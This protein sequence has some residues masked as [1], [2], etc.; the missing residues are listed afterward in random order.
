[1]ASL[2]DFERISNLRSEEVD[3]CELRID[4]LPRGSV[5]LLPL[6]RRLKLPKIVTVRDPSEGGANALS[7]ELRLQLFEQ[8]LPECDGIDIELRNIFRFANLAGNGRNLRL[9]GEGLP[10]RFG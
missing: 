5:E 3:L 2:G 7:E 4:L 10:R 9:S 8:W 1:V 6:A